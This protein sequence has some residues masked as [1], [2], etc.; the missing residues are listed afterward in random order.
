M[1][2]GTVPDALLDRLVGLVSDRAPACGST[3]VVA[4][5]GPSGAGKSELA[6]AL[7]ART[8]AALLRFDDLYPGWHGLDDVPPR[9]AAEVLAPIAVGQ[10]GSIARWSWVRDAPAP[11]VRCPPVPLLVLDGVG[12]GAAAIRPFLSLLVWVDAP[13]PLRRH[14]GLARDGETYAPWW[15]VW[16]S[17][18]ATHFSREGTAAFADVRVATGG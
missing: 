10:V 13:A 1:E 15:D 17:Q 9:V 3:S 12:S 6:G 5:D 7:V 16:A 2:T 18:E 14:R 4:I 8:G 11:P